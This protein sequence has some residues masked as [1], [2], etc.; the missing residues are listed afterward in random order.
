MNTERKFPSFLLLRLTC[1][2]HITQIRKQGTMK[3][4]ETLL[5][6]L[7]LV[8]PSVGVDSIGRIRHSTEGDSV[9]KEGGSGVLYERQLENSPTHEPTNEP[10]HEPTHEN[11]WSTSSST[12]GAPMQQGNTVPA[13]NGQTT[14]MLSQGKV[15]PSNVVCGAVQAVLAHPTN[16]NICFAGATNGGVWRTFSC[17]AS[18]PMWEPLTDLQDSL[19]VGDMAFDDSDPS[20]N[21]ILVAIGTLSA[22]NFFSDLGGPG[23]G[24]LYTQNALEKS[25]SW[26]VLD[27]SA[28]T[29]NFRENDVKFRSAYVREN[30]V[31][32]AAYIDNQLVCENLGIFR[33]TDRGATWK[34]TLRGI[35]LEIAS[36]PD[37]PLRFYATLDYTG[38]CSDGALPPNGVFHQMECLLPMMREKRGSIQAWFLALIRFHQESSTTQNSVYRTTTHASGV[39]W[40]G[41][42]L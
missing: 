17:S 40:Y 13:I 36:D 4:L 15:E 31:L 25:P 23:I 10:T 29:V 18:E 2:I 3:V 28:G 33:S 19:S 8:N 38:D 39:G 20:G 9:V 24:L 37:D 5:V 42:A 30:L 26:N 11:D 34:N 12:L 41:M 27:N 1:F 14:N 22:F 21:T 32:A 6:A 35:G 16:P 7:V